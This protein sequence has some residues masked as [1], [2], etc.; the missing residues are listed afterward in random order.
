MKKIIVI[1]IVAL[2][3]V[4]SV[5]A[6]D[7]TVGV[8]SGYS[9]LTDKNLPEDATDEMEEEAWNYGAIPLVARGEIWFNKYLGATVDAGVAF[10]TYPTKTDSG[11]TYQAKQSGAIGFDFDAN[12]AGRYEFFNGFSV[13]GEVGVGITNRG[14]KYR[15]EY[16]GDMAGK[17]VEAKSIL[18]FT[19]IN[20]GLGA[21]YKI[22]VVKGLTVEAGMNCA[23]PVAESVK[24]S[25]KTNI[26]GLDMGD[27][28]PQKLE[29]ESWLKGVFLTPYIALGY[30]F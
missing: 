29:D 7:F 2:L 19:S 18:T 15:Q 10:S 8:K 16:K 12:V 26:E 30:S 24:S 22:P 27:S 9:F 21:Q 13:I 3:L 11:D 25:G 6:M 17:Y 23:I 28:D 14:M 1:S 5:F 20:I 4:S